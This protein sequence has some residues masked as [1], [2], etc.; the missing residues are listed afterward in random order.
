M[1]ARKRKLRRSLGRPILLPDAHR[2]DELFAEWHPWEL[3]WSDERRRPASYRTEWLEEGRRG[4]RERAWMTFGPYLSISPGHRALWVKPTV[5]AYEAV[6]D[7]TIRVAYDTISYEIIVWNPAEALV[8]AKHNMII[9]SRWLAIIDPLTIPGF[10]PSPRAEA[11]LGHAREVD[12]GDGYAVAADV[13]EEDGG[14][15]FAAITGRIRA[16]VPEAYKR[17][18]RRAYDRQRR[19]RP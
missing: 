17:E 7:A 11:A 16:E 8:V 18:R 15:A 10:A 6:L 3:P 4:R 13:F 1:A 9:G 19:R 14:D 5:R 12:S 2:F